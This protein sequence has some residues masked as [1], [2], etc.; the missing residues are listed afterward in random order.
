M[1]KLALDELHFK[2]EDIIGKPEAYVPLPHEDEYWQLYGCDYIVTELNRVADVIPLGNSTAIE[3]AGEYWKSY[4]T[5]ANG[6][7]D[8][9]YR[10]IS[11]HINDANN[12]HRT[13]KVKVGLNQLNNWPIANDAQIMTPNNANTYL[14]IGGVF[15]QLQT[16]LDSLRA[17]VQDLNNPHGTTADQLGIPLKTQVDAMF[18]NRLRINAI[19]KSTV[20]VGGR[21][22]TD[23]WNSARW[24]LPASNITSGRFPMT[25]LGSGPGIGS[26]DYVLV[27]NNT[28]RHIDNDLIP[29]AYGPENPRPKMVYFGGLSGLDMGPVHQA[30]QVFADASKYPI[31]TQAIGHSYVTVNAW[32]QVAMC[33]FLT[34]VKATGQIGDW[35]LNLVAPEQVPYG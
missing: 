30:L 18:A 7:V 6:L 33:R 16:T 11:A 15:L 35:S 14:P 9:Y 27:G 31:G 22:G 1:D 26:N 8:E 32:R 13:D 19:A 34:R 5:D 2:F 4:I 10:Q 23:M 17:H 21:D 25:L 29:N 20:L 24:N 28:F 12:P 3:E